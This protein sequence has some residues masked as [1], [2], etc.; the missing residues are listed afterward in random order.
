M[1]FFLVARGG[2]KVP[3]GSLMITTMGT[4]DDFCEMD[5]DDDH[6]NER[7]FCNTI[8]AEETFFRGYL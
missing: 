1:I 7:R 5:G 2:G 4:N 6:G 8:F 3:T